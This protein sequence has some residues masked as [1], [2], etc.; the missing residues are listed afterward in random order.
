MSTK[1]RFYSLAI[2]LYTNPDDKGAAG[3]LFEVACRSYTSGRAVTAIKTAGKVDAFITYADAE[4]GKRVSV[5]TE[6]KTGSGEL[7]PELFKADIIVYCPEVTFDIEAEDQA[8]VFTRDEFRAMLDNYPGRGKLVRY[9]S[10][11]GVT[12]IQ[13]FRTETSPTASAPMAAYLWECCY[14]KPTLREWIEEKRGA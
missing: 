2:S 10:K 8:F 12:Q 14:N 6:Y 13:Q 3:K 1:T 11:R 7:K 5:R 4:T 9:N